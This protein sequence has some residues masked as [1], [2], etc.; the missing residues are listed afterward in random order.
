M[1]SSEEHLA[2]AVD[3][4][5][6]P[7]WP[8]ERRRALRRWNCSTMGRVAAGLLALWSLVFVLHVMVGLT[9]PWTFYGFMGTM[10]TVGAFRQEEG[11]E[12]LRK[13]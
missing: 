5:L 8:H 9:M 7:A 12:H 2:R 11:R 10:M 3:E 4:A 13:G 1:A 6:E